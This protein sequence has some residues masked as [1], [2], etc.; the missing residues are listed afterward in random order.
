MEASVR[1]S[2]TFVQISLCLLVLGATCIAAYMVGKFSGVKISNRDLSPVVAQMT[3]DLAL[4]REYQRISSNGL[5]TPGVVSEL[6]R[7]EK[8]FGPI[9][10]FRITD[11]EPEPL[12]IPVCVILHVQRSR[13]PFQETLI[14]STCS[15]F[16]QVDQRAEGH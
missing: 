5:C 9:R 15:P 12:G 14:S 2:V 6:I 4:H 3:Y 16:D 8:R 7:L 1:Y 10:S 13:G 11:V